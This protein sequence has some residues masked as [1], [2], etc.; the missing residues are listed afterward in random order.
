M[1]RG[2]AGG[3]WRSSAKEGKTSCVRGE[4]ITQSDACCSQTMA[5]SAPRE[6]C[7]TMSCKCD[8]FLVVLEPHFL[9]W[10]HACTRTSLNTYFTSST[11]VAGEDASR[12]LKTQAHFCTVAPSTSERGPSCACKWGRRHQHPNTLKPSHPTT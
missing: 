8:F 2:R 5:R 9:I 7:I 4:P 1:I 10:L 3:S 12:C 6:P 11:A